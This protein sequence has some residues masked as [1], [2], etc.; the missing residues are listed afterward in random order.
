M[1]RLRRRLRKAGE[2]VDIIRVASWR[3]AIGEITG[4]SARAGVI[5]HAPGSND[6]PEVA[7]A[8]RS[9][10]PDAVLTVVA[11]ASGRREA[12]A[13]L[14]RGA[15]ALVYLDRL[16]TL[17]DIVRAVQRR[18]LVTQ[19]AVAM[20]RSQNEALALRVREHEQRM[21]LLFEQ[22]PAVVMVVRE[23]FVIHAS[24]TAARVC[25][26]PTAAEVVG[27]LASDLIGP[28]AW[29]L[30][31]RAARNSPGLGRI[32]RSQSQRW[33]TPDGRTIDM[34]V[35]VAGCV[36]GGAPALQ[37]VAVDV[38]Q[39]R[40]YAHE[41]RRRSAAASIATETLESVLDALPA[42]IVVLDTRGTIRLANAPWRRF[43]EENGGSEARTG[44]GVNYL[45]ECDRAA[46]AHESGAA[47][48]ASLIREVLHG[49]RDHGR[50]EYTCHGPDIERWFTMQVTPLHRGG[51]PG[52][53]VMHVDVSERQRAVEALLATEGRLR[54]SIDATGIGC[55]DVEIDRRRARWDARAGA[56]FG[57]DAV[58]GEGS[59]DELLSRV[60]HEHSGDPADGV[61]ALGEIDLE[62]R[63]RH[64]DGDERWV[65]VRGSGAE[66]DALHTLWFCWDV[67]ERRQMEAM[68]RDRTHLRDAVA[69]MEQVLGVVGHE[70]RTPLAAI[71]AMSEMLLETGAEDA[72]QHTR[73]LESIRRETVRAGTLVNEALDA[74]RLAHDAERWRWSE[75]RL[76]AVLDDAASCVEPLIDQRR[77]ALTCTV[78]PAGLVMCGDADAVR[79]M[80][81]NLAANAARH[82]G[83][84]HIAIRAHEERAGD[85]NWVVIEV[86]DTGEGVPARV[87][88][89]LGE[90]FALSSG[91][92]GEGFTSGAG[93]GL[94]ICRSIAG[95]HGGS[96]S[97]ASREGEGA[98]F[99]AR[100]RADLDGPISGDEAPPIRGEAR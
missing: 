91:F 57:H 71:R 89:R 16:E 21:H 81:L 61:S 5:L 73:F 10:A 26:F 46:L 32:G 14:R 68:E 44:V 9:A 48:A 79:R 33:R 93:L 83:E 52:A 41:A 38:T 4:A 34:E 96:I 65:A 84:G 7:A 19:Q 100:L 8:L 92:V 49:R 30:L 6:S 23:G 70:L 13:A 97:F 76:D 28:A 2:E 18:R 39:T 25:G 15:D 42:S 1:P 22:S 74:A 43:A 90:A 31:E 50:M 36:V 58:P 3:E 11:D 47:R 95:A 67:S 66:H 98:T 56:L 87:A 63:V 82:T 69:A 37:I 78:E 99:R 55:V 75:F 88:H 12:R 59:I 29:S 17:G 86:A 53:V 62:C 24:A 94:A 51:A 60:E 40:T 45:A 64:A 85:S 72:G 20:V 80:T 27:R 54:A 77:V 35:S